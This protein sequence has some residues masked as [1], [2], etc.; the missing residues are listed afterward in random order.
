M[1]VSKKFSQ[2]LESFQCLS[3]WLLGGWGKFRWPNVEMVDI[4]EQS[5][6]KAEAH[7]EP[8]AKGGLW[9]MDIWAVQT[10]PWNVGWEDDTMDRTYAQDSNHGRIQFCYWRNDFWGSVFTSRTLKKLLQS[11]FSFFSYVK[12]RVFGTTSYEHYNSN[13]PCSLQKTTPSK[14]HALIASNYEL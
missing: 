3:Q 7:N 9:K 8:R 14:D 4:R 13:R 5:E 2:K 11:Y 12:V 6:V 10:P 1:N